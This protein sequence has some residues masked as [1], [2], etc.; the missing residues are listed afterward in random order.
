MTLLQR[1]LPDSLRTAGDGTGMGGPVVG[2]VLEDKGVLPPCEEG[3]AAPDTGT[4]RDSEEDE[5]DRL[6]IGRPREEELESI[7]P[8][9]TYIH[10]MLQ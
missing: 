2:V 10:T 7:K 1:L 6:F 9:N 4:D 8:I 3:A 5:E